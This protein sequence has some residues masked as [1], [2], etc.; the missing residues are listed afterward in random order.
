MKKLSKF[1]GICLILLFAF[2]LFLTGF[3]LGQRKMIKP[4]EVT[5]QYLPV[6]TIEEDASEEETEPRTLLEGEKININTAPAI[7]LERL[8][9]I[10]EKRAADIV[11]WRE[12]N[13]PFQ[14][15]EDLLEISGLGP[16]IFGQIEPYV[17]VEG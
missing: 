15:I 14:D 10:G 3:F 7:E 13:G 1:D 6:V 8:P 4:V 2:A 11:A 9:G 12:A 16:G 17:T 5:T